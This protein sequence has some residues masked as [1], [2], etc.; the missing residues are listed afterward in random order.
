MMDTGES[1]RLEFQLYI[2]EAVFMYCNVP[3][4]MV[5]LAPVPFRV[6]AA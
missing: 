1:V 3:T 6:R 2:T 5:F 4:D